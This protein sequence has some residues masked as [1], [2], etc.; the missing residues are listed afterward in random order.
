M[1][2]DPA[3]IDLPDDE[4][5]IVNVYANWLYSSSVPTAAPNKPTKIARE[6]ETLFT[7]LAKA[8]AFGA[9]VIDTCFKNTVLAAFIE[10]VRVSHWSPGSESMSIIYGCTP[11]DFTLVAPD[12]GF[13][14]V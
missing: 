13:H 1:R 4:L 12:C 2:N 10:V 6:A 3:T 7:T 5:D 8:Y 14:R 11:V 9:K